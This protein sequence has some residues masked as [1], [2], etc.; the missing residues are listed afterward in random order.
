MGGDTS[1]TVDTDGL[2][3]A[4]GAVALLLLGVGIAGFGIHDYTQQS[5][6]IANAVEVDATITETGVEAVSSGSTSGTE[7][8]PTVSF[9]YEYQGESYTGT[10]VFPATVSPTYETRAAAESVLQG[11]EEGETVTAYVDPDSPDEAFLQTKRSTAPLVVAAI[12]GLFTII[13]A[14]SYVRLT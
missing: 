10:N 3:T 9:R 11:L 8:K 7:Y 6:A 1:I 13:G 2:K 14:I 12:G 5:D 4:R